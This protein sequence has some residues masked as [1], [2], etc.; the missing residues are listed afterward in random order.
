MRQSQIGFHPVSGFRVVVRLLLQSRHSAQHMAANPP[1]GPPERSFQHCAGDAPA[2]KVEGAF[3]RSLFQGHLLHICSNLLLQVLS[4]FVADAYP[5]WCYLLLLI[6]V[7]PVSP[8][9]PGE[10]NGR[11]CYLLFLGVGVLTICWRL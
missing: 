10:F 11:G 8:V 4:T 5:G 1:L 7:L 2:R 9:D 6:Q 3:C